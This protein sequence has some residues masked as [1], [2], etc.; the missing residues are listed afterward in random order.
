MAHVIKSAVIKR[1]QGDK[2]SVPHATLAALIAGV[3]V[4]VLTHRV[5]RN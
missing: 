5:M 2:P 4:A 1:V 3:A